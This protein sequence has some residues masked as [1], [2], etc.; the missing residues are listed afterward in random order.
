[1]PAPARPRLAT[2]AP[3]RRR[4][5]RRP[6][7]GGPEV[8]DL[9]LLRRRR[10]PPHLA[11]VHVRRRPPDHPRSRHRRTRMVAGLPRLPAAGGDVSRPLSPIHIPR[12]KT[13]WTDK[14][15]CRDADT[16]LFFDDSRRAIRHA[17]AYCQGCPVW[18]QCRTYAYRNG[19]DE[20]V[21]GGL[22]AKERRAH[23]KR[24][25]KRRLR[26]AS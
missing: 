19:I 26:E 22:S 23:L 4:T 11:K 8:Q 21:W 24:R 17:K 5:S 16:E 10:L 25:A 3:P 14:A 2:T 20:G 9:P 7:S 15:A 6:Q 13:H 12:Q 1:R 18:Q